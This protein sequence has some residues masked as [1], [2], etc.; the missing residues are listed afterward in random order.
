MSQQRVICLKHAL[1]FEAGQI[2]PRPYVF[3]LC[4][5]QRQITFQSTYFSSNSNVCDFYDLLLLVSPLE[6]C[7]FPL[8]SHFSHPQRISMSFIPEM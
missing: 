8:E 2:F 6:I 3:L 1:S 7:H 5:P 4:F